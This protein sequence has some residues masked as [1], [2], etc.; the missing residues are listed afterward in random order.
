MSAIT[1]PLVDP[2]AVGVRLLPEAVPLVPGRVRRLCGLAVAGVVVLGVAAAALA[3]AALGRDAARLPIVRPVDLY[4]AL[5]ASPAY[6]VSVFAGD[7]Q[8]DWITTAA[9]I[10][11]SPALWRRMHLVNWNGV[12]EPLRRAGLENMLWRYRGI[13]MNPQAWDAM[14]PADWDRVPQPIR[15]VA[16]RQMVAYWAG[17]YAVGETWRLP[18]RRVAETLAAI[19]MS[20]SW[21][22]HRG[23]LINKDGTRDIGLGGSSDFARERLRQLYARGEVDAAFADA[24]Y[25][26]PWVATRFVAI[27]MSLLLDE[28]RGDLDLAVRAY[29]R[30]M[31]RAG[32]ARGT[33][34]LA[35]V[36]RR[37]DQFIRN[38][39]A[40]PAW[41]EV[42]EQAREIERQEWPWLAGDHAVA[43]EGG[44]P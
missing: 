14:R 33:R 19:V 44:A 43:D 32:D 2:I 1:E 13:L 36:R 18:R 20:E 42:W 4:A 10:E 22:D 9:D 15:T 40:P 35:D 7:E 29:N 31:A 8:A 16:Y 24:D 39:S 11:R 28:A 12:P 17:F 23:L 30:G 25:D 6:T 38:R 41:R 34:Y 27:W 21:F 3:V 26:N 5:V 37:L